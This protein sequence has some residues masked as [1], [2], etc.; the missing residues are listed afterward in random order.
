VK[1]AVGRAKGV[2]KGVSALQ[3]ATEAYYWK[4]AVAWFRALELAEYERLG[5]RFP[6]PALD[7][8][9]GDGRVAWMLDRLGRLEAAP[10]GTDHSKRQLRHAARLAVHGGLVR[11]DAMRLPFPD[12]AFRSVLC[13][14]VICS[15]PGD[16]RLALAEV[17]RV[18]APSGHAAISVPTDQ[19]GDMLL[20]PRLLGR[21]SSRLRE[22]YETAMDARQPHYWTL[23]TEGWRAELAAAGFEVRQAQPFFGRAA[24]I[25]WNLLAMHA[26]RFLGVLRLVNGGP[27]RRALGSL[28]AGSLRRSYV[29]E[30]GYEPLYGQGAGYVLFE[31]R[32]T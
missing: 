32:R 19:F 23:S 6:A 26:L 25:R 11:S 7:L 27:V 13:N 9:C 8:G 17:R 2:A 22:R 16:Y 21:L 5:L 1:N 20:W 3:T 30:T 31:V 29:R 10:I 12:G 14:G 4:P 15:I 24:G 28:V 18:L